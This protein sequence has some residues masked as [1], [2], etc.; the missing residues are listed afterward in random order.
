MADPHNRSDHVKRHRTPSSCSVCRKRKSKCDRVRPVCGSCKKKS[1]AHLCFYEAEN[2]GTG[3]GLND[4]TLVNEFV[5]APDIPFVDPNIQH[6]API[7]H[8]FQHVPNS[9]QANITRQQLPRGGINQHGGVT[10]MAFAPTNQL[11]YVYAPPNGTVSATG[12]DSTSQNHV[13]VRSLPP[14][15]LQQTSGQIQLSSSQQESQFQRVQ[16]Q[17]QQQ[18][19]PQFQ[20]QYLASSHH[21]YS[22]PHQSPQAQHS[23]A[24]PNQTQ[25]QTQAQLQPLNQPQPVPP[26]P[27]IQQLHSHALP[28]THQSQPHFQHQ[29]NQQLQSQ[30]A[31]QLKQ[32]PTQKPRKVKDSQLNELSSKG[33]QSHSHKQHIKQRSVTGPSPSVGDGQTKR[34]KMQHHAKVKNGSRS[35]QKSVET[36]IV[37]DSNL[38]HT[39]GV[40]IPSSTSSIAG[41]GSIGSGTPESTPGSLGSRSGASVTNAT[42]ASISSSSSSSLHHRGPQPLPLPA[43]NYNTSTSAPALQRPVLPNTFTPPQNKM[44]PLTGNADKD[45]HVQL[46]P[47]ERDSPVFPSLNNLPR[48]AHGQLLISIVIGPNSTLK[49]NPHD[50]MDVFSHG[51]YS[52][53][54]DGPNWQQHGSLS[55][56]AL[57]KS[58]PFIKFLRS[59]AVNL[60]KS[61]ELSKYFLTEYS[62]K[63]KASVDNTGLSKRKHLPLDDNPDKTLDHGTGTNGYPHV[64]KENTDEDEDDDIGIEDSLIVSKISLSK[65]ALAKKDAEAKIKVTIPETFLGIKSLN[66]SQKSQEEFYNDVIIKS[67]LLVLPSQK[68]LFILFY[69][70]FKYVHAF[71]PI[72]DENSFIKDLNKLFPERFPRFIQEKYTE[73]SI[74]HSH[75]L[76]TLALLLL[77]VRLGYMSMLHNNEGNNEY[78]EDELNALNDMKQVSSEEYGKV[79]RLCIPDEAAL[80]KSS[81]KLIQ[82][83]TLFYFYRLVAPDD[84]HGLSGSDGQLT[85]GV[86]I[87]HAMTIGLNRDPSKFFSTLIRKKSQLMSTWR[88]LWHYIIT[89]DA[90]TAM[91][92]GTM[93]NIKSLDISDVEIPKFESKTGELAHIYENI[94]LICQSYRNIVNKISNIKNKPKVVSILTETNELER[95]FFNFFGKD[96]FKDYICLPVEKDESPTTPANVDLNAN[97]DYSG[98]PPTTEQDLIRHEQSYIKVIKFMT[99]IQL[100]T[101]LSCMYYMIAVHYEN[102]YNEDKTPSMSAGIEL[103][104]I[105]IKSVVQLVYIMSYVLDHSVELF[106]KNYDYILTSVNERCMIKT[107]SFLT[108][109]FIRLLHHIKELTFKRM[110]NPN[111]EEIMTRLEVLETLFSIV[112]V[113]SELF[114]GN[115][116]KL[117]SKYINSYRVYV[118]VYFVIRQCM[119]NPEIFFENSEKIAGLY[120]VGT[121]MIQFFTVAEL[122]HLCRMCEEFR[123]AKEEQNKIYKQ[124]DGSSTS[125]NEENTQFPMDSGTGL[126]EVLPG[127][128]GHNTT[129]S[130]GSTPFGGGDTSMYSAI[131]NFIL[132]DNPMSQ[133]EDLI[134]L[135]DVY[136]DLD[137]DSLGAFGF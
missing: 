15:S 88:N 81:L 5:L 99:F 60:F 14:Q 39:G 89:T 41:S 50:T 101:N 28:L 38:A 86:I 4:G 90:L 31:T 117:S 68:N 130:F 69:R 16:Q 32:S 54:I 51:S 120:H 94:D 74:S 20:P 71:I 97:S 24:H 7:H 98:S 58:D 43:L 35:Q 122:E 65:E 116:R 135:F 103:F 13:H 72:I 40:T 22:Q 42:G 127:M 59:Y 46:A 131:N 9:N 49:V 47:L 45:H 85:L 113:E 123:I 114:V 66:K 100:R 3:N 73:I 79:I 121:N 124:K 12:V 108:S 83:L 132:G 36:D 119:A 26:V 57:T 64:K 84:C 48:T 18:F 55:Y 37:I 10:Q 25:T 30:P 19:Q 87:K 129:A 93:L 56:T 63:R 109:F 1:I 118:M 6:Q 52:M 107:H 78:G 53:V 92:C 104:K 67:V 95:I 80:E 115:F 11:L 91:H 126:M 21:Q 75:D 134:K 133:N 111:D 70:Y 110:Q 137:Q 2:G 34:T 96:F 76:N 23:H 62:K 105:Y 61:G 29:Q 102:K 128:M 125:N 44:L 27:P 136:T 77:T 33:T 17:A 106:G 8:Q 112:I 82:A